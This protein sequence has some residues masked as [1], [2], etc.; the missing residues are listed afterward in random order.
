MTNYLAALACVFGIVSGQFL[1]KYCANQLKETGSAFDTRFILVLCAAIA[2][3]GATSVGW[4]LVLQKMELGRAYPMM[5]VAFILV[6]IGSHFLFGE[7]L[8]PMYFLGV[9][10][11]SIGIVVAARS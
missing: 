7:K 9:L 2:L 8:P 1:F 11:I 10:L 5:A 6:P 3:Y 4:I